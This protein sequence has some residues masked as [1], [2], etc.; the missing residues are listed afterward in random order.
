MSYTW[1]LR[2]LGTRLLALGFLA[3]L[4]LDSGCSS[5]PSRSRREQSI[6]PPD[7]SPSM[8]RISANNFTHRFVQTVEQAA[9]A[10]FRQTADPTIKRRSLLW[11]IN[12]TAAVLVAQDHPA[13][14]SAL[15]D[16]YALC[17][18]MHDFFRDG[19]GSNLFGA[20]QPIAVSAARQ[21]EQDMGSISREPTTE[22][23][24]RLKERLRSWARE[25]PLEDLTFVRFSGAAEIDAMLSTLDGQGVM[26]SVQNLETEMYTFHTK[27]ARYLGLV[28][29]QVRWQAEL[30]ALESLEEDR[31]GLVAAATRVLDRQRDLALTD[32]DRQRTHALAMLREERIAVL[33]ALAHEREAMV[34]D[35]RKTLTESLGQ[36]DALALRLERETL[37]AVQQ[38]RLETVE[39]LRQERVAMM[40]DL[41]RIARGT[42][43]HAHA[44]GLGLLVGGW[45]GLAALL[46]LARCLFR[47][48]RQSP[49]S[50]SM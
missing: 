49:T 41:D 27:L 15:A 30:L 38:Q 35:A 25:H 50:G 40:T 42:V 1:N 8:V 6:L 12:A 48:R 32:V 14:L 5:V 16:T 4:L 22:Q 21:L 33:E 10:I 31:T 17:L 19:Q 34:Q 43:D 36:I 3:S 28:P 2:T 37:A 26:A 23:I 46:L 11:K 20:L 29:R 39:A 47:P 18:Q 9:D 44:R 13:P 7:V 24:A 45:C